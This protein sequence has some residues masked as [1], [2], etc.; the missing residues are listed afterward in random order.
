MIANG[1][2]EAINTAITAFAKARKFLIS[3]CPPGVRQNPRR[4]YTKYAGYA[5]GTRV[6]F[7][8]ETYSNVNERST[9]HCQVH[10]NVFEVQKDCKE[11]AGR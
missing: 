8:T 5:E 7:S 9:T 4:R 10:V 11:D 1:P 6:L 2:R 3:T